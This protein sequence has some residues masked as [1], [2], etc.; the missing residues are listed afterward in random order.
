MT[1]LA[2]K[3]LKLMLVILVATLSASASLAQEKPA[4]LAKRIAP[5]VFN[6]TEYHFR[7]SQG[8]QF[9]FTPSGQEN[10]DA[11]TDMLTIW[12]YRDVNDGESLAQ[13]AN[14]TL[15]RYRESNGVIVHTRSVPK[16]DR[17]PAEHFVAAVLGNQTLLEF[18]AARFLLQE[19]RGA[20]V[21]YSHRIYGTRLGKQMNAWMAENG[22]A[23]EDQVM[24]LDARPILSSI[25]E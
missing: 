14:R 22:A 10:L 6:G 16:T 11:W 21:I 1:G 2:M 19:G 23:A 15:G 5:I 9:E 3:T 7:W 20:S 25:K 13:V 4:K 18:V 8:G 12:D 24:S 17:K